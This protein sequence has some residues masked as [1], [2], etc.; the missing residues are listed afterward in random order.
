MLQHAYPVQSIAA[1]SFNVI[2]D[3]MHTT[4]VP[5]SAGYF[6]TYEWLQHVLTPEGKS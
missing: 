6:V 1:W 3:D 4:D 5:A 2:V